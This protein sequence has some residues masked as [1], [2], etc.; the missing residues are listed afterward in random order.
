MGAGFKLH[1]EILPQYLHSDLTAMITL[2]IGKC[3]E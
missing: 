2:H 1:P 3:A